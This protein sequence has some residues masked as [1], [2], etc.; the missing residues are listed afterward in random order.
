VL[1]I[2]NV[3][4][5]YKSK[6]GENCTAVNGVSINFGDK[7][8][9]F[10][11]GKSGSGKSTL[12]NLLSGLDKCDSGD[13][14][15]A[16]K[17]S[18][19]FT[20]SDLDIYRN[21]YVG[22]VFQDFSLMD[23]LT[24]G[25]NIAIS[26]KLQGKTV[27]QDEIK[28][29]LLQVDLDDKE[30]RKI[31]ELSGGQKQRVAIAR[32]LIKN[33]KIIFADE[34]TGALDA[35][36]SKR[37]FG[38]LRELSKSRLVIVVSHDK[39]S[40]VIYGDRI[41][42]MQDGAV[43]SDRT[44]V[45]NVNL[46]KLK[47]EF[48]DKINRNFTETEI[49]ERT[50]VQTFEV[51]KTH[52]PIKEAIKIGATNFRQKWIHFTITTLLTVFALAGFALSLILNSYNYV[53]AQ[54]LTYDDLNIN[55]IMVTNTREKTAEEIEADSNSPT[56]ALQ[57]NNRTAT[58]FTKERLDEI[59]AEYSSLCKVY[60]LDN[61]EVKIQAVDKSGLN[62]TQFYRQKYF[63][64]QIKSFVEFDANGSLAGFY[65]SK[66]LYG[67]MPATN[68]NAVEICIS[69]Y[70]AES[71][72]QNGG[73]FHNN[74]T[75]YPNT[76]YTGLLN[77]IIEYN[78]VYL[79]ITG[80]FSTDFR[81]VLYDGGKLKTSR[82]FRASFNLT[83]IY[84]S[85]IVVNGALY[86]QLDKVELLPVSAV[87]DADKDI[88]WDIVV[89]STTTVNAALSQYGLTADSS[90]I[91]FATGFNGDTPLN[92]NELVVSFSALQEL[93]GNYTLD[94]ATMVSTA[95]EDLIYDVYVYSRDNKPAIIGAK[96][97]GVFN[98][99]M[100]GLTDEQAEQL[101]TAV[102]SSVAA[103]QNMVSA[104]LVVAN[105]FMTLPQDANARKSML[106]FLYDNYFE[107]LT[108]ATA[109]LKTIAT[110]FSLISDILTYISIALCIFVLILLYNF[111]A[112]S[113]SNK[114]K[115]IGILRSL[116]ARGVDIA[117]VFGFEG[118][119]IGAVNILLSFALILIG[120]PLL[121]NAITSKFPTRITIISV[122]PL[123]MLLTALLAGAVVA[124]SCI[125]PL[126]RLI[127]MR[128][129]DVLRRA[130]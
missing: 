73:V 21:T 116:G 16:G 7:G 56:N 3:I 108:Y 53:D 130:E 66:L 48:E 81:E 41:I 9:V 93:T 26:G 76:G 111:I 106:S 98:D 17:S 107:V 101:A 90:F 24:V 88:S 11:V 82:D 118:L 39:D 12:L 71:V 97:V 52:F 65:H 123:S 6:D 72:M 100:Q 95:F 69:D 5:T 15:I 47:K 27:T 44:K 63:T 119:I 36:T 18:T 115:E 54:N 110:L 124:T 84:Q 80:I 57:D 92:Y 114:T 45:H 129:V 89:K 126:A 87:F 14:I 31:K 64:N 112:G 29:A 2:E 30:R 58:T 67:N 62:L 4:K 78:S 20:Q 109:E 128:P 125:I 25:E 113:I 13:I 75:V 127:K 85:A 43:V 8:L 51:A 59:T 33:P 102:L 37:V 105:V 120:V 10:V 46:V 79:K 35:E 117:K 74:E 22:F 70:I 61:N 94:F 86:A 121:N 50:S 49:N 1:K 122:T 28:N 34:P 68:P 83:N 42:E 99:G 103:K 77:K 23:E 55:T 91:K 104:S 60:R 40:A 32:A 19:E 96:I 38:L